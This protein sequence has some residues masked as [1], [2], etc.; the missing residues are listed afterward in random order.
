MH[1]TVNLNKDNGEI[2]IGFCKEK[3]HNDELIFFCKNHNQLCCAACLCKIKKNEIGKHK[4]CDACDIEAIKE[5]K[6]NNLKENIKILDDLSNTLQ[7]SIRNLKIIFD[8]KKENI[9][10]LKLNIQ[11]IFTKIRNVINNREDQLLLGVD[12]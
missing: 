1:Q 3:N 8:K 6:K 5:E 4:D 12:N 2:F 9:E 10:E 7:E 11:K